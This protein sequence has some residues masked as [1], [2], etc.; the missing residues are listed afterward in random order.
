MTLVG[1][2]IT[3]HPPIVVPEVGGRRLEQ[4]KGTVEAMRGAAAYAEELRPSTI[5]LLSPHAPLSRREM[6]V[7]PAR[8]YGGSLAQFGA[9]EVTMELEGDVHLAEDIFSQAKAREVP[10]A[11]LARRGEEMPLDHGSLVPLYF[12]LEAISPPP[13]LVLLNFSLLDQETHL[14]FGRAV[15]AALEEAS[16]DVLYVASGDLSHRLT[17]DAPGGFHESGA[18][19]DREVVTSV[20]EGDLRRLADLPPGLVES[21]GECG[22]RSLLVLAGVLEQEDFETEVLSYE[23]PFGVGYLVATVSLGARPGGSSADPVVALARRAVEAY[24]MRGEV[25]AAELPPGVGESQAGAFVSLH[26][27]DGS[28]RGCIGTYSPTQETLAE[29]IV[30]NA[31]SAA[32]SDPRFHPVD[33]GEL[34]GLHISVDVLSAP[35]E[36]GGV[37]DLDPAR[38]GV[39]VRAEDGRQALLLPDLKGVDTAEQQL[40]LVCEKGGIHPTS[41]YYRIFRF[42]VERHE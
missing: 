23:G 29:E 19:F 1:A 22:L 21:A 5:V 27:E 30:H 20:R 37:E 25:V 39:I 41:D 9:P 4:V 13:S 26:R 6:G 34:E 24:V 8:K 17:P 40:T 18:E 12:L 16:G 38:Y 7:S 33:A 11:R 42:T 28:L 36:V 2:L 15:A 31:I 3:P 35:E 14:A 10:V 32:R